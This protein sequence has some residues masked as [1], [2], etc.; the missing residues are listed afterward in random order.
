MKIKFGQGDEYSDDKSA[1]RS[2]DNIKTQGSIYNRLKQSSVIKAG[3]AS[4]KILKNMCVT[5]G[6]SKSISLAS[7]VD[8]NNPAI[9][10]A[11]TD[12]ERGETNVF[13]TEGYIHDPDNFDWSYPANTTLFIGKSGE[14]SPIP[15]ERFSIQKMGYIVD[16]HTVYINVGPQILIEETIP[17]PTPTPTPTPTPIP[18][19]AE[20]QCPEEFCAE[21]QC[22]E[23]FFTVWASGGADGTYQ[24]S[25]NGFAIYQNILS[26]ITTVTDW[27]KIY[28]GG[29]FTP[30][31]GGLKKDNTLWLWGNNYYGSLAN[32]YSSVPYSTEPIQEATSSTDWCRVSINGHSFG[33]KKDGTLWGWGFNSY[34]YRLGLGDNCFDNIYIPEQIGIDDTWQH[35]TTTN[36]SSAG[37]KKDGSIWTWGVNWS[38]ELANGSYDYN[39][40]PTQEISSSFD[41]CHVDGGANSFGHMVALKVDGTLWAWGGNYNGRI[42]DGT[43]DYALSPVQEITNSN[44]WSCAFAGRWT[45]AGI[46]SDGT[47]WMW[48]G[49]GSGQ[50][51]TCCFSSVLIPT[52][53]CTYSNNWKKVSLSYHS[54]GLKTDGTLW[55]WGFNRFNR[56][57]IGDRQFRILPTQETRSFNDWADIAVNY[58]HTF[59][60]RQ[61]ETGWTGNIINGTVRFDYIARLY[62]YGGVG[63]YSIV[64]YILPQGLEA[65]MIDSQFGI[66]S[67]SGIPDS[68]SINF[69]AE[70]YVQDSQ[71]EIIVVKETV[72]ITYDNGS[73]WL[74]NDYPT[75]GRF[76][77]LPSNTSNYYDGTLDRSYSDC[78]LLR[79]SDALNNWEKLAVHT[80]SVSAIKDDGSLWSWGCVP[81]GDNAYS[82]SNCFAPPAQEIFQ[83]SWCDIGRSFFSTHAIKKDGTLWG[84]GSNT[85]GE[86]AL[87]YN[88]GIIPC[89]PIQEITSS[90]QW[91]KLLEL[92][93]SNVGAI[94]K[95][96]TMWLWGN[97]SCFALTQ[98]GSNSCFPCPL[99]ETTSTNSWVTGALSSSGAGIKS[100]G[101]LW[102]WGSNQC[103]QLASGSCFANRRVPQMELTSSSNW[104]S[105]SVDSNSMSALKNN[106]TLWSWGRDRNGN[107][108]LGDGYLGCTVTSPV[109]EISSSNNWIVLSRH[110]WQSA[111]I[112]NDNTL[113]VWGRERSIPISKTPPTSANNSVTSPTQEA[114]SSTNWCTVS[115]RSGTI[116]ALKCKDECS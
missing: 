84:W 30:S 11:F 86:L 101:T 106:G 94:K 56:L 64:N 71:G 10:V 96:G 114:H 33:I 22:P 19:C 41:W 91:D 85:A 115:V 74:F 2:S 3:V 52:Q 38:G 69:D 55:A 7:F 89:S 36:Y 76:P 8:V 4:Q 68:E 72:D 35:V 90:N 48:G 47:L 46:K 92:N 81:L 34:G 61:T 100:D 95:D 60:L 49:S 98:L 110:N 80:F 16:R 109:Q 75:L 44:Q 88:S 9:G 78:R 17:R 26:P 15:P 63:P 108:G 57:P 111:G 42:G 51:G 93:S 83:D 50:V 20:I 12:I 97:N 1:L 53:E 14:L 59:A 79:E 23:E 99:Q 27:Y 58:N 67:I 105:V 116:A 73:L 45:S 24:I 31:V 43:T 25:N 62:V 5:W 13:I 6:K 18:F 37:L 103:G 32:E 112:K 77:S 87:G 104:C 113:W 40:E 39:Y 54:I 107:S 82:Y 21:I 70:I 102:T 28:A 65:T 29:W 66:I